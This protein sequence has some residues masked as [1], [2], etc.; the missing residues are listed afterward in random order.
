MI[1]EP[2]TGDKIIWPGRREML[3]GMSGLASALALL[4]GP[5]M[6]S[7][8]VAQPDRA[9]GANAGVNY[10]RLRASLDG[11]PAYWLSRG[12]K[13]ALSDF[14]ITPIHGFA[15][16]EGIAYTPQPDG[17]H[18]FRIFEA[19]YATDLATGA[20]IDVYT[21]PLT[22]AAVPIP[23]VQPLSLLYAVD[24]IGNLTIPPDDP[25]I[26]K[27]DFSGFVQPRHSFSADVLSEERF[28]TRSP[29]AESTSEK[30]ALTELINYSGVASSLS[31]DGNLYAEARKSIVVFRNGLDGP[32]IGGYPPV[33]L[34]LYEGLKFLSFDNA[35]QETGETQMERTHPGFLERLA[36]FG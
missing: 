6:S 4:A 32:N 18:L 15:M 33:L 17:R 12:V 3:T 24:Q 11:R 5:E 31:E 34:A 27:V 36:K 22:G 21:N 19:P 35:V 9:S 7:S 26:G 29:A 30:P 2:K 16:L 20:V 23:H 8:A 28:V 14:E 10:A 25:R 13:Y 1:E